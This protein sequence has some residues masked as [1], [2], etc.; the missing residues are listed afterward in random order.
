M[1]RAAFRGGGVKAAVVL[2]SAPVLLTLWRYHGIAKDPYGPIDACYVQFLSFFVLAGILPAFYAWISGARPSELGLGA[3][4][5]RGGL[6]LLLVMSMLAVPAVYAASR[7]ADVRTEYPMCKVLHA[8]RDLVVWYELAYAGLFYTAW[9]FYFRG[10][11]LFGLKPEL[12]ATNALLIQ[13]MASSLLHIGKPEAEIL[14]SI[15]VGLCLGWFALRTRS[16]WYAWALHAWVGVLM[17][18]FILR[19]P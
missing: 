3:G 9:E 19:S 11:L 4:D 10:F 14:C 1:V 6:K 18:L 2:V 13:T 5:V 12:G 15:P 16:I 8:Q 17:D 7:I